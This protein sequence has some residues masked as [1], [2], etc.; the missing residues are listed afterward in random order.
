M[1]RSLHSLTCDKPESFIVDVDSQWAVICFCGF[2]NIC[3]VDMSNVLQFVLVVKVKESMVV[4][5]Y[6]GNSCLSNSSVTWVL[7]TDC[8]LVCW[9]QLSSLLS[10]F[11]SLAVTADEMSVTVQADTVKQQLNE[12]I[13][14]TSDSDDYEPDMTTGLKFLAEQIG[15]NGVISATG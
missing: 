7:G 10:H 14:L 4:E 1:T 15:E 12:L 2:V 6:R 5:V 8:K 11:A 3:T 9:S 13:D